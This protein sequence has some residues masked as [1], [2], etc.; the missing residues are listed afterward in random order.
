MG[1]KMT[2]TPNSSGRTVLGVRMGCQAFN[3][4]WRKAVSVL[5][6][7][8][9]AS[10]PLLDRNRAVSVLGGLL[11]FCFFSGSSL[12]LMLLE[13]VCSIVCDMAL[14]CV[15]EGRIGGGET[16][17]GVARVVAAFPGLRSSARRSGSAGWLGLWTLAWR[18]WL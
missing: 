18:V 17:A 16:L 7:Q 9:I 15:I 2:P 14:R 4:C 8:L 11:L 12:S 1:A 6:N 10:R 3:R 13:S 5:A